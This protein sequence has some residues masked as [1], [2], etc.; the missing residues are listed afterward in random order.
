MV[1]SVAAILLG[2]Q[3][4]NELILIVQSDEALALFDEMVDALVEALA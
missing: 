2:T 3:N 1:V 4:S